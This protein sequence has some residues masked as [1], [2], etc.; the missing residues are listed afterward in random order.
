V[1]LTKLACSIRRPSIRRAIQ[2]G[3]QASRECSMLSY[4]LMNVLVEFVWSRIRPLTRMSCFENVHQIRL[5][6]T[7]FAFDAGQRIRSISQ[8]IGHA[9]DTSFDSK[10][11]I[12]TF[13]AKIAFFQR[14]SNQNLPFM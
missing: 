5:F 14:E 8:S 6:L 12:S 4:K 1:E 2:D 10:S 13:A 3:V 11:V 9:S 7:A